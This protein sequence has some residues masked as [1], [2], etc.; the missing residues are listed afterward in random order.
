VQESKKRLLFVVNVDWFFLSHRLI[1]AEEAIK[2]GFDVY[3]ATENTGCQKEIE[4]KGIKFI[5][6]K[7]SRSGK[8]PFI[9]IRTIIN[10]FKIY[11]NIKPNI[12]HH[13]TLKPVIYGSLIAKLL[14]IDSVVNAISGLGY[15]FI[16]RKNTVTKFFMIQIMKFGFYNKRL[17]IIFQN[18]DDKIELEKHNI[19][20]NFNSI[21]IIKGSGVNLNDYNCPEFPNFSK[22]KILFPTRMLWDKGVKELREAT[23][24]LKNKYYSRIEFILSGMIDVENKAGVTIDYLKS[25]EDGSYVKWIGHNKNMIPIYQESHIVI[26]PSYREGLPKSLIEA[27]AIGRAIITTNAIGCKDCVDE[28]ING[29]KVSI[30]SSLE[31]SEAVEKLIN[32]KNDIVRMGKSSRQ[33]ALLEFS[34]ENVV[35]KHLDI[36]NSLI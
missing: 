13:V 33:K 6:L 2:N 14:K 10:L 36:Y 27:C 35:K 26:L 15:I 19:I 30:G 18:N 4:S 1:I 22:I 21:H 3:L 5:N 11:V 25:W 34:I 28:G 9:E 17:S 12:V 31:L 7:I 16:N 32:S 24:I 8:N 29:Y 23:D 20:K